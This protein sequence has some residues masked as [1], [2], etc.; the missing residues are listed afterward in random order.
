MLI[1]YL[2]FC[3]FFG[4]VLAA[5]LNLYIGMCIRFK[6]HTPFYR[7]NPSS[8]NYARMQEQYRKRSEIRS[9]LTHLLTVLMSSLL[10]IIMARAIMHGH[11]ADSTTTLAIFAGIILL[12]GI[13]SVFLRNRQIR[14][15]QG[16]KITTG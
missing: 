12:S 5:L 7:L 15:K 4:S 2:I 16:R 3:I 14:S 6:G 10:T 1:Q 8:S 11:Q 9:I 13:V